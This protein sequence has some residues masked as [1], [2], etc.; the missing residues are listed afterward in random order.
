MRKFGPGPGTKAAFTLGRGLG[1]GAGPARARMFTLTFR[2]LAFSGP[3]SSGHGF[4]NRA[5][6]FGPGSGLI[7]S[8]F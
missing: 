5:R 1:P 4:P 7:K 6:R 8:A 3:G 2:G